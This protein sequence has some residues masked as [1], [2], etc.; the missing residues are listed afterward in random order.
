[1]ATTNYSWNL[2]TVGGSED[3]WGTQLNANWTALDTLLNGVTQAEISLLKNQTS[4]VPSGV[5][6]MWSGSVASVPSGWYLCDGANGTPNLTGR[7]VVHADAD[8]G[9]TYA[10]GATGGADSVTLTT[11]QIPSHTHTG[12][13]STNGAHNHNV[14][15]QAANI[16]DGQRDNTYYRGDG[17]LTTYTT[18]TNGDHNHTF[19]T[20]AAGGGSSHENRPPY[21]ALAYIMKA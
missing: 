7:F 11:S 12:T 13:T 1:M 8:S 20:D 17:S 19:T 3:T 16:Q 4:L 15:V 21:Y 10:P 6:V 5:I 18:T 14:S 9:G 2:P